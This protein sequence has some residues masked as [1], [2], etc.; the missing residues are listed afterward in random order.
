MHTLLHIIYMV[1]DAC[2]TMIAME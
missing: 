1:C 2:I